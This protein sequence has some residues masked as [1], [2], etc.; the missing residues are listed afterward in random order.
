MDAMIGPLWDYRPDEDLE[1]CPDCG[2]IS[3]RAKELWE[4]GGVV[5]TTPGCD[6]WFCY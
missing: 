4:G 3:V 6:Y 1:E 5:C 2:K